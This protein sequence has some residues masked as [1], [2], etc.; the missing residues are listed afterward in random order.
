MF[1]TWSYTTNV[2]QR[3]WP[4]VLSTNKLVQ[5]FPRKKVFGRKKEKK[6]LALLQ[7]HLKSS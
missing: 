5:R 6:S 4:I 1:V 3:K 2:D 7:E